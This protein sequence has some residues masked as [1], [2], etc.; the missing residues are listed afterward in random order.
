MTV[1]RIDLRDTARNDV[2]IV[3]AGDLDTLDA[4]A[5]EQGVRVCR[6]S[7]RGC[8]G[9]AD[10]LARLAVTLQL[11]KTFGHNWDALADCLRDLSW[12]PTTGYVLLFDHADDL[13][14]AD[15]A[16]F[17]TAMDLFRDAA[18]FWQTQHTPFFAFFALPDNA[19]DNPGA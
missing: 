2:Y 3:D 17:D 5:R 18:A 12:R 9:K 1:Q 15:Q 14:A 10:L 11:P 8:C 4:A 16:D 13:R 6:A 19:F 7:L